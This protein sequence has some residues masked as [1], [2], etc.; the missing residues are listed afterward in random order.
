MNKRRREILT[1]LQPAVDFAMRASVQRSIDDVP[2]LAVHERVSAQVPAEIMIYGS[3][4]ASMWMDGI[5]AS[6]VAAALKE[7]GPGPVN[8]RINSGGGDVFQGIAIHTLLARHSGIVSVYV[9]G[10]AASAASFI[11]LAGDR[12]HAARNGFVMIHDAMTFTYGNGNT[13]RDA[14]DLLDKV[15]DNIADMYAESAGEDPAFWRA[16]MTENGEDGFWYTGQEAMEAGLVHELVQLT[17]GEEADEDEEVA[18][19]LAGWDHA[20]SD[21]ARAFVNAHRVPEVKDES[22]EFPWDHSKVFESMKGLFA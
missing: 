4:G 15:S 2:G 21:R 17:K 18:A 20:L 10:L 11:M 9:D 19:R 7:A 16:K 13:H 3:I 8:V 22:P 12:I 6:D 14:A 1:G 5:T